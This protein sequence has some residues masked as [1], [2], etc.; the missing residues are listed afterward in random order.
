MNLTIKFA[1]NI[2]LIKI[3]TQKVKNWIVTENIEMLLFTLRKGWYKERIQAI[4]GFVKLGHQPVIAELIRIGREDFE[5]VAK[6]AIQAIESLDTT[7]KYKTEV[8]N[9]KHYW[10]LRNQED[11]IKRKKR[12]PEW[13][14]KKV[15][16]K[17]LERLR[18]QLKSSI[19]NGTWK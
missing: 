5:V 11:K 6:E 15:K 18:Q 9:L 4:K 17:N 10:K 16:M 12:K 3:D 19:F 7:S 8:G 14:D 1:I 2:G 13:P